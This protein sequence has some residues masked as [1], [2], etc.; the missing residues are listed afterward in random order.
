MERTSGLRLRA[1]RADDEEA[2]R[3]AHVELA[4]EDFPFLLGLRDEDT[5]PG[6][7]ARLAAGAEGRDLP[8]G[9]VPSTFLVAEVDGALVG[10]VS[11]RHELNEFLLREGG[12]VGYAVRPA[13]RGHGY[14]RR[15]LAA[16]LDL[17]RARGVDRVL[18]TCDDDNLASRRTIE[19]CGG[20]LEDVHRDGDRA[21]RRYW[22]GPDA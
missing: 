22:I 9:F 16:G 14:A 3:A 13:H 17:L 4:H 18:V 15:M 20:E 5:W 8:E 19:A 6:Y 12:H 1:L 7:L 10:R 11:L 2:A 21:T